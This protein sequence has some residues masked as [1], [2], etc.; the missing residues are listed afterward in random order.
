MLCYWSFDESSCTAWIT[1]GPNPVELA[2]HD[3][4]LLFFTGGGL[5][6]ALYFQQTVYA[7][8]LFQTIFKHEDDIRISRHQ[9]FRCQ[10]FEVIKA[11]S[12]VLRPLA[13]AMILSS[14]VSLPATI[15]VPAPRA[16]DEQY[17]FRLGFYM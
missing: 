2:I 14:G 15:M 6:Y 17:F 5:R 9:C 1:R 10:W 4:H 8:M 13:R 3:D 16:V 11:S 12:S 7:P